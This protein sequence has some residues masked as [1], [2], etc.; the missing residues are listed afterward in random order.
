MHPV[1]SQVAEAGA[2]SGQWSFIQ[3]LNEGA[4]SL[5]P[6]FLKFSSVSQTATTIQGSEGDTYDSEKEN[7]I[8]ASKIPGMP[9]PTAASRASEVKISLNNAKSPEVYVTLF[10][11]FVVVF[12]CDFRACDVLELFCTC[13]Y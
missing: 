6:H 2:L 4:T 9:Y 5:P 3:F 1:Q 13:I 12:K 10:L 7:E 11:S 8:P